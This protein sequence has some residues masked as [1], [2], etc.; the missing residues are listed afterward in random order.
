MK[1]GFYISAFICID[2]LQNLLDIK[3]RHD[4]SIAL[5][6]YRDKKL[7]LIR[8]WELE[9]IS[10]IKQHPKALFNS[11]YFMKL[12][13][14]LLKDEGLELTDIISIWGIKN[15]EEDQNYRMQ[16]GKEF[17][18][19][20]IAHL[21]TAIFFNNSNPFSDC[22]LAMALDS[23]PDSQFEEDA[24]ERKYY[25]ACVIE[26]G[27]INF[28]SVESPARLWSYCSKKFDLREGT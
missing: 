12:L 8:Y 3:L 16:F 1:S 20:S 11:K 23:G 27:N 6:E 14:F 2:E 15:L 9:R 13:S 24:Y 5:W 17:A 22:I 25:S 18:F 28:F 21:L 26:N 4:Q 19:H 10:G 7:K